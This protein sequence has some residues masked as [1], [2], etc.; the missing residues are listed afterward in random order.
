AQNSSKKKKGAAAAAT[1]PAN[2]QNSF[3]RT[4]VNANPNAAPPAQ[5]DAAEAAPANSPFANQSASDLSQRASDG[6]LIN[7]TVNNGASSPFAQ[8]ASFGNN[9]R[10]PG[11]LYNGSIALIEDNSALDANS[12][13][14]TGQPTPKPE[15]DN[16][17]GA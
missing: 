6:L 9:R 8:A 1:T 17:Q 12:F 2:P 14:Y 15:Q 3:Q 4:A 10:G 16:L 7:G 11:S 13:S 5:S